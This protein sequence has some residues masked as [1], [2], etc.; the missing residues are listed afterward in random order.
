MH[1]CGSGSRHLGQPVQTQHRQR[2]P[3]GPH[4]L[5]PQPTRHNKPAKRANI[6][7]DSPHRPQL[8]YCCTLTGSRHLGQPVQTQ[9][10]QRLPAGPH[11]LPPTHCKPTKRAHLISRRV[12]AALAPQ[13]DDPVLVLEFG[14]LDVGP[15][16]V[17]DL[18]VQRVL[19][20]LHTVEPVNRQSPREREMGGIGESNLHCFDVTVNLQIAAKSPRKSHFSG[21]GGGG[22]TRLDGGHGRAQQPCAS[23]A[24]AGAPA[25]PAW[26]F[27]QGVRPPGWVDVANCRQLCGNSSV[28]G[29]SLHSLCETARSRFPGAGGGLTELDSGWEHM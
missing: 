4:R 3:A 18:G 9:Y 13:R 16:L 14:D 28:S 7:G 20:A 22:L 23:N 6:V 24:G 12:A 27:L 26:F 19:R 11:G 5:P 21:A 2:L 8:G 10:R 15:L 25:K 1:V 29:S 17:D